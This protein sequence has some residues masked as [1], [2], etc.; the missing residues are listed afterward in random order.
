MLQFE[1]VLQTDQLILENKK[2]LKNLKQGD[3]G[4]CIGVGKTVGKNCRQILDFRQ[5]FRRIEMSVDKWTKIVVVIESGPFENAKSVQGIRD[6][7]F[8]VGGCNK[9]TSHNLERFKHS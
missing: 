3:P 1:I 5:T 9:M 2:C 8:S 4:A 7:R 6:V